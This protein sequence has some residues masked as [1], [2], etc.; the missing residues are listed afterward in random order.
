[1]SGLEWHRVLDAEDTLAVDECRTVKAGSRLLALARTADG[2]R[3]LDN[4]C[5]HVGGPL[6]Q[7]AVDG[8]YLVCPWHGRAYH[9]ITGECMNVHEKIG[10]YDVEERTDGVYVAVAG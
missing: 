4:G 9:L 8:E 2:Y 1:M 3:A 5:L 10:T 7:G 6:G